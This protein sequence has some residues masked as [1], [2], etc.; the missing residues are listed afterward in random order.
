MNSCSFSLFE[1]C[2]ESVWWHLNRPVSKLVRRKVAVLVCLIDWPVTGIKSQV[3]FYPCWRVLEFHFSPINARS[4]FPA[5]SLRDVWSAWLIKWLLIPRIWPLAA[6]AFLS[7]CS[8][9]GSGWK[10]IVL[11]VFSDSAFIALTYKKCKRKSKQ[12]N[13]QGLR[14]V[15][16]TASKWLQ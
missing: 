3:L 8:D 14:I 12:K 10:V 4:R 16:Q 13:W 2:P 6:T 15:R 9:S 7:N 11:V 5:N 1:I